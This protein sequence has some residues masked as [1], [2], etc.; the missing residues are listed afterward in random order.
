[1]NVMSNVKCRLL[2]SS[3]EHNITPVH[4]VLHDKYLYNIHFLT[5][6]FSLHNETF[7]YIEYAY[8]VGICVETLIKE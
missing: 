6:G 5:A 1:M 7:E 8:L 3:E 4:R 2:T